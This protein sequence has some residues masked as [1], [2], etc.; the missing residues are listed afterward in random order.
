MEWMIVLSKRIAT[1]L[2]FHTLQ[3]LSRL[4]TGR[5]LHSPAVLSIQSRAF[6]DMQ[7][8]EE[9]LVSTAMNYDAKGP[10]KDLKQVVEDEIK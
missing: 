2:H 7:L 5:K 6:F 9:P 4:L 1:F 10:A 8:S 3:P